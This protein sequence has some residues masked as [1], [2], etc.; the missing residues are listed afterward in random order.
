MKSHFAATSLRTACGRELTYYP[1][2]GGKPT[3]R[4]YSDWKHVDCLQCL[5][6]REQRTITLT[7]EGEQPMGLNKLLCRLHWT[8]RDEEVA[9]AILAVR[10]ALDPDEPIFDTPVVITVRTYFKNRSVQLDCSNI[11]AKLY[12]DGLI[13]WLIEDDNPK[14][15]RSMTTVSLLDR[16]NPRVEIEIM[17]VTDLGN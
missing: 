16:E 4:T 2:D 9:R 8:A 12:E 6:A 17:E 10:V 1:I 3:L 5:A 13:G 14:Y 11:P 15:V 7:L